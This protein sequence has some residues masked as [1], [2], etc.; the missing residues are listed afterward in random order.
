M[1]SQ[2]DLRSPDMILGDLLRPVLAYLDIDDMAPGSD[3]TLLLEAISRSQYLVSL[4]A[5]KILENTNLESLVG[6]ALDKKAESMRLPNTIGGTGR[7]PANQSSGYITISSSFAKVS[8]KFYAG[9]PAPFSG[10]KTLY[11]EDGSGFQFATNK[12]IYIGR[13]T[14]DRFEGPIPYS[15]AVNMGSFWVITLTS[16]LTK[17]HLYSDIVVLA[18]G[19]DRVINAGTIVQTPSSNE[20]PAVSFA[21]SSSTIIPDGE[22]EVDVQVNC[23]NFGEKGNALAGAIKEFTAVPFIGAQVTNKSTF[24]NGRSTESDENLRKRIKNYPAT[25]G[26]GT[27]AAIQAAISGISD[28]DTGRTITS[29]VVVDPAE[30]GDFSRVYI[31]DGSG[32]EPTFGSQAYELL[33]QS[34]SGQET[35]FQTAQFPI[36]PVTAVGSESGPFV[37]ASGQTITVVVDG[38]S[39][40]YQVNAS[41][42]SNLNAA[43]A[44]EIVRDFN[45]Q[46]NIVGFRTFDGGKK[47]TLTDLSGVAETMQI[48]IGEIQVILGLPT[49]IIRPIFLYEDSVIQSFKGKTA[50]LT[51]NPFSSWNP[52]AGDF[53]NVPVIV[54]G[55]TQII[56]IT[57]ADFL[58][59]QSDIT[60]ATISQ[61]ATV[62]SQKLAG[63]KFEVASNVL[64]WSTRQTT[65]ALGSLEIPETRADGSPVGW[66]G[67][68]RMWKSTSNGGVLSAVGS[69]KDFQFNRFTGEIRLLKK[70]AVGT[71]IEI[72]TRNTRANIKSLESP[73]G[74]Y[75]LAPMTGT[76]GHAKI[77]IGF[78]GDFSI[79]PVTISTGDKF[80][81]TIPDAVNASNVVRLF[82]TSKYTFLNAQV[83]D[84]IYLSKDTAANPTWGST[85]EGLYKIKTVGMN[86]ASTTVTYLSLAASV[87]AT[88]KTVTI[89][90]PNHG[91]KSGGRI[92]FIA[93]SNI[94]GVDPSATLATISVTDNN[95]FTYE[96]P[97]AALVTT[98]G[99][100]SSAIYDPDAWIEI[101]VSSAQ[102]PDWS[103]LLGLNQNISTGSMNIFKSAGAMPQIV[104]FGL[105]GSVSTEAVVSIINNQ[106][107]CGRCVKINGKQFMIVSNDWENGS[108]A[109][110]ASISSAA[111]AILTGIAKSQQS[112]TA[113][114]T[115][116]FTH[117]GAPIISIS[118]QSS[119][120]PTAAAM[121][122]E[123]DLTDILT[124]GS[125]PT[126]ASP[127]LIT[128][129]PEGFEI[130]WMTGKQMGL[131]GRVY[132]NQTATPYTGIMRTTKAISPAQTS[133]TVQNSFNNLNRYANYSLRFRDMPFSSTDKLVVE[134][135]LDPINKTV[136]VPLYKKA[137]I[138]DI[139]AISG[140]GKGQVLSFRLKDQEDLYDDD[141][142][143]VTP[144]VPRPFFHPESVYKNFDFS[145]FKMLTKNVG[146][147]KQSTAVGMA[148]FGSLT[149]VDA[150]A[151]NGIQDGDTFTLNDG[152]V[153]KIFEFDSNTSVVSGHVAVPFV[154]GN[155]ASGSLTAVA[156]LPGSLVDEG[157]LITLNDGVNPSF[158]FE[159]DSDGSYNPL[160]IPIYYTHGVKA[161]GNITS[162]VADPLNGIKDGDTFTINDGIVTKTFE[163]DTPAY[164]SMIAT[165][166]NPAT[167]IVGAGP[168]GDTFTL[169]DGVTSYTFEFVSDS[170]VTTNIPV[171]I[172]AN[173]SASVIKGAIIGTINGLIGFGITAFSGTGFVID[174]HNSNWG[175]AGNVGITETLANTTLTPVGM[176][177]AGVAVG[178]VAIEILHTS[179]VSNVK[180]AIISAINGVSGFHVSALSGIGDLI[181]LSNNQWGVV[182]NHA[183]TDLAAPNPTVTLY[184]A[185]MSGGIDNATAAQ[186]KSAIISAIFNSSIQIDAISAALNLITLQNKF[187]GVQGNQ[188]VIAPAHLTP[189]NMTGGTND[190]SAS[191][192][193]SA[194]VSAINGVGTLNIFAYSGSA[195]TVMLVNGTSGI[196]GN[197][198]ITQ[199]IASGASLNPI[200]MSNGVNVGFASDRVLVVRSAEF[201]SPSKLRIS[202]RLP[203]DP[204][205]ALIVVSHSNDFANNTARTNLNV[206][207]PS[208]SAIAGTLFTSGSFSVSAVPS[209][210]L[211][212]MTLTAP[213]LNAGGQYQPG[214]VLKIGGTALISGSYYVVSSSVGSVTVMSPTDFGLS[215]VVVFNANAN[216]ISGFNIVDKSLK[217]ISDA[218]NLYLVAN[219]VASSVSL[220]TTLNLYPV[221]VPTYMSYPASAPY[222][223][224]SLAD[225][226]THH[227]FECKY[228]GSAG[229][230]K[231]DS[232]DENLNNIKAT[233]QTDDSIFPTTSEAAGTNYT[234]IGEEVVLVPTNSKTLTSWMNFNAVSSLIILGDTAQIK[235]GNKI[236]LSSKSDGSAGGVKI[237]GVTGNMLESFIIGNATDEDYSTKIKILSPDA[238]SLVKG[239]IVS[240]TNGITSEI[241]RPYRTAPSSSEITSSNTESINTFFRPTNSIKYKKLSINSARLYFFRFG[242]GSGQAESLGIGDAI[243]LSVPPTLT[244]ANG[245]IRVHSAG[246]DLAARVGDMMYVNATFPAD[247]V[248]KPISVGGTT[249]PL[250]PEYWGYPVIRVLDS[251]TIDIIAPNISSLGTTT[252]VASTDLVF[253]PAIFNEKNIRSNKEEGARFETDYN[254][255]NMSYLI[256]TLGSNLVSFWMQNSA[257][258]ATDTMRLTELGVSTDDLL[259]LGL[260]F[261]SANQGTF[262]IVAH[263]GKNHI[264]FYNENGGKDEI[265]DNTTLSDGGIGQ[266]KWSVGPINKPSRSLR[267]IDSESVKIGDRLRISTPVSTTSPWFPAE[268]FGSWKILGIGYAGITQA[269]G[270]LT[271]LAAAS[272][273][274]GDIFVINDG[275]RTLTFEF[276]F[277]GS[278]SNASNIKIALV[279]TMTNSDVAI[280]ISN[281]INSLSST[282]SVS[283]SVS[284]IDIN[285]KNRKLDI[286]TNHAITETLA[287]GTLS[288]VG[289]TGSIVTSSALIPFVDIE[290]P[291]AVAELFD[292]VTGY[293]L[294]K[295]TIAGN[296]SSI[297]FI[298]S[299]P[300]SGFRM[301][302]GHS[303][304]PQSQ[305]D[306]DV[307]LQPRLQTS[308]MSETFG[309]KLTAQN[310]I[311]FEQRTF[312]GIDG[313]KIFSGLVREAHRIIDGLPSNTILYP[314]VKAN[315]APVDV[316]PPLVKTITMSLQVRPKDGVTI[317]SISEIIKST[318]AGYINKLGVGKPVVISEV[319]KIVQGLPGVYSVSV[320][321]TLPPVTDDRIVVSDIETAS[322]HNVDTD[323]TVG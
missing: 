172:G 241:L 297:G 285:L 204:S 47:I 309:T 59:F 108:V 5:L 288:P 54:D 283:A 73:T 246:G 64:I 240:I 157:E 239:Q 265:V 319:I 257:D 69:E 322:V 286:N 111:N 261:D 137:M 277:N 225:A 167:G 85:I 38:I 51:T 143:N 99:T 102:L 208:T 28:P 30:P 162:F 131:G 306:A 284:G 155:K 35:K 126:I 133:D 26:R 201:G 218:I 87:S 163:F 1:T 308:K 9:K 90:M 272:L 175:I 304:S 19:G 194:M 203:S 106:I 268:M 91:L 119:V 206:T 199:S 226:L 176:S 212:L 107:A 295:F 152:I 210:S 221:K 74:L 129:Y 123:K 95:T 323:I 48:S 128:Q 178:N 158:T 214:V 196:I 66:I 164:G 273:A 92:T 264:V 153:T 118:N 142:N 68:S 280:Q 22:S 135:D 269:T 21:T 156:A 307:F 98:P 270:K 115:S 173:D 249:N 279:N 40:T 110:L 146:L 301:V 209:G 303:V 60:S 46:S 81:P 124:V 256:K 45:S 15:S 250:S 16:P 93:L 189:V 76:L 12:K 4:G 80:T 94:G 276:S 83:G 147:Y 130:L 298:E 23:V 82:S 299:I 31:D 58:Q 262:K 207:L 150:S 188:S 321:S 50:T 274:Q 7:I 200:G 236:Q 141:N 134:M 316:E 275:S 165:F 140:S 259:T 127:A 219:P 154:V 235:S 61:W 187:T 161:T 182:G 230:W 11:I 311:G 177:G 77:I 18:Q 53:F 145:D 103:A 300:Y 237:T 251:K 41:N 186:I 100:I 217:D 114:S 105:V 242:M 79:R 132:N 160:N 113:Y 247:V 71:A 57:N 112:H 180:S 271:A 243:T 183:I 233:A 216:P 144:P 228:A 191:S 97:N 34:A 86:I 122:V 215:G 72:G 44:Y 67:D 314:G 211:F 184:P 159:F 2:V 317:N 263:N 27:K 313:Y 125:E 291:N 232:S 138:Q 170:H 33:L 120:H 318:V 174:L 10:S 223:G 52:S 84:Y 63:V 42:Y 25:L 151:I 6:N 296:D 320:T 104:D 222:I 287:A 202:L 185:G 169:S 290:F 65:S 62:F 197:Q 302:A 29:S 3:V 78:D 312:Q 168:V 121:S 37:L 234:P 148:A 14:A 289:I 117:S 88:S 248:C 305:E 293:P 136:A 75:S 43:T 166:S 238:K 193:K 292:P 89:S 231:Y 229:I 192:I 255:G 179:S 198:V 213:S 315:G 96:M 224:S 227:S 139:D 253:L 171:Y 20:S 181:N 39:E 70:P 294:D 260:G 281:A 56:T 13:G 101:E 278:V 190:A 32:L 116:G 266:R 49:S 267:I 220:G 205:S 8:T 149:A 254:S 258:E 195:S 244:L 24:K 252:L 55:V 245:I 310:K 36:T 109:V 282:F 17:N